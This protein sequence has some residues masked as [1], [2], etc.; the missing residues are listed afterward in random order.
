MTVAILKSRGA[1]RS[2]DSSSFRETRG[3]LR[4]WRCLNGPK[5]EEFASDEGSR[6]IRA[7]QTHP[8]PGD[9]DTGEEPLSSSPSQPSSQLMCAELDWFI[10][11]Y[12]FSIAK[13]V[14]S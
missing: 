4:V 6:E 11:I 10:L 2:E 12:L 5:I 9:T 13:K 1:K 14:L 7:V 3:I 8:G